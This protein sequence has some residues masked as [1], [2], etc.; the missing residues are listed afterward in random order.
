MLGYV[1]VRR[2]EN[3]WICAPSTTDRDL[4]S[5]NENAWK[6]APRSTDQDLALD[7]KSAISVTSVISCG[8]IALEL[9]KCEIFVI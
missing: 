1:L 6:C 4:E 2:K 9:M 7:K 5:F 3:A 8:F